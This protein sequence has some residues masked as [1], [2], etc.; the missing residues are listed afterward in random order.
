[1]NFTADHYQIIQS[2]YFKHFPENF[3]LDLIHNYKSIL[4]YK[5]YLK[6]SKPDMQL[7]NILLDITL[8]K[9]RK[10]QRFQK[11]IV[12]KLILNHSKHKE[13]D[14]LTKEKIFRL[15]QGLIFTEND[16]VCWKLSNLLK[17]SELE[18]TQVEWLID[19]YELSDHLLNRILRY[20]VKNK[21]I[22]QWAK[23]AINKEEMAHRK[24]E[25]IGCIL[26]YWPAYKNKDHT[27]MAWG[28]FYSKLDNVEK[29]KLLDKYFCPDNL[30]EILK[31]CEREGFIDLIS[32][33]YN[34][35]TSQIAKS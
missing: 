25:I 24:S 10:Q 34:D 5:E 6:V 22:S 12:I 7:L 1:M 8:D 28:I 19:N 31:I 35:L 21:M 16:E 29:R 17:N 20:P 9:I 26:N 3:P 30:E 18:P 32:N 11:L 2:K 13:I 27:A 4:A 23:T 33:W 15:Y 14:R